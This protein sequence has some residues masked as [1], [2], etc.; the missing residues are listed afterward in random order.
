[1]PNQDLVADFHRTYDQWSAVGQAL[2]TL[3]E[4]LAF[5][6]VADV[7]AGTALIELHGEFNEDWL[8]T[9]RVQRVRSSTGEVLF[10]VAEGHDD[11]RVEDAI[12]K[13]NYEYLDLLLDLSGDLHMGNSAIE[14]ELS[15]PVSW[16]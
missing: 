5:E 1:M 13:V 6:T 7:L 10:D 2:A 14:P 4:R 11:R 8:R 3:A 12:A 16:W 15:G 9:L